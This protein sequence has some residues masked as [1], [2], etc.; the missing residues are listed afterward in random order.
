M[1][2][3]TNIS[4]I[5]NGNTSPHA[6]HVPEEEV[7]LQ[8]RIEALLQVLSCEAGKTV[9][10]QQLL[11][12]IWGGDPDCDGALTVAVCA[13][14]RHLRDDSLRP[15]YVETV[16]GQ[17]YRLITPVS[18]SDCHR[19]QPPAVP[20]GPR[21]STTSTSLVRPRHADRLSI[22]RDRCPSG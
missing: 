13:L 16:R 2:D 4:S 20:S 8:P 17:G 18:A 12:E 14:R 11:D 5:V 9:S 1:I 22:L 19:R 21:G 15:R 3:A 10:R 7:R 6:F